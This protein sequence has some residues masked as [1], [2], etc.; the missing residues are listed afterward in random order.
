MHAQRG[1][2][3]ARVTFNLRRGLEDFLGLPHLAVGFRKA[4]SRRRH[5]INDEAAF[6]HLRQEIGFQTRIQKGRRR[7]HENS[8]GHRE[9]SVVQRQPQ[10]EFIKP[11]DSAQ[12]ESTLFRVL[13]SAGNPAR[14]QP[15]KPR[16][17]RRRQRERQQQRCQQRHDHRERQRAKNMPTM[18]SRNASGMNTTTGVSVEPSS[19]EKISSMP[20]GTASSR[21]TPA[22]ILA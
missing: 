1:P 20:A 6:V 16:G 22:A 13:R 21:P 3:A 14:W 15:E 12:N 11:D 17:E 7:Q 8:G 18:P 10:N 9:F 2:G 5:I 19:A 4:G